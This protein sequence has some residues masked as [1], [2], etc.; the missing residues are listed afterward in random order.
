MGHFILFYDYP[1]DV[2]ERR[3]PHREAHLALYRRWRDEGRLVMGGAVGDPPHGAVI[4][5]NVDGPAE[6]EEFAA[7][8]PYVTE[9]V[10]TGRRVEPWKVV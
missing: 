5:F 10:A 9:G 7:A 2:L 3:A 6:V 8:D 4:V 1:P